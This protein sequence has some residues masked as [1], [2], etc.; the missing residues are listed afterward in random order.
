MTPA[1][2][3]Q[4]GDGLVGLSASV[5][6]DGDDEWYPATVTRV[7]NGNASSIKKGKG[8][9]KMADLNMMSI[10]YD[11]DGMEETLDVTIEKIHVHEASGAKASSASK[12]KR[13]R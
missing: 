6:W 10:R 3:A 4:R 1:L 13:K 5:Y 12:R 7:A 8:K 11:E 9:S 2:V